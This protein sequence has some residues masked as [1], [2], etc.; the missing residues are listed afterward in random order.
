MP[1]GPPFL[2]PE[3]LKAVNHAIE[4]ADRLGLHL[5]MVASSSWNAG[6]SW[7]K[8]HEAMKGIY[9]SDI[10]VQGPASLSQVL[11]FPEVRMRRRA[12]TDCRSITARSPCSPFPR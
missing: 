12:K 9:H 5:G 3:S 11:P 4:Q 1:A 7:V 10:T 6:G 2:G 8:P